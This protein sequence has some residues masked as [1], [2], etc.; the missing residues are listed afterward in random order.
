MM[1]PGE[2]EP[3]IPLRHGGRVRVSARGLLDSLIVGG[4]TITIED[5]ALV[6]RHPVAVLDPDGVRA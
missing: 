6:V 5:G 1:M 2:V 3:T 4:W